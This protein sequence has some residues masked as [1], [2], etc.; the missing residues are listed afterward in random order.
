[1][2]E[3]RSRSTFSAYS[4]TSDVPMDF[5]SVRA[6]GRQDVSSEE[7]RE[8]G[9]SSGKL[10]F[11][12][13]VLILLGASAIAVNQ[14]RGVVADSFAVA[15]DN[16]PSLNLPD[17]NRPVINREINTVRL[18]SPLHRVTAA[19]VRTILARYTESGFLGV[20]VQDLRDELEGNPWVAQA[21]VR[22]VWPDVL[23]VSIREQ[24]PIARWS[25]SALLNVDG[26]IFTPPLRGPENDL[27]ALGGPNGTQA[28]VWEQYETFSRMLMDLDM[29]VASLEVSD[30]GSWVL[31][32][33][34]GPQLRLGRDQAVERLGRFVDAYRSGLQ[35]HLADARTIDLRYSNGFSVSKNTADTDTVARR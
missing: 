11:W 26:E 19:D 21:T 29:S 16:I 5:A 2:S 34:G 12:L 32:I 35:D 28:L 24:Q 27:P 1:M 14:Y 13:L 20:D 9:Q 31:G 30:R 7:V 3:S 22:R 18:D 8:A 25:E 4:G 33:A 23:V 17:I 15:M 6:D 10:R